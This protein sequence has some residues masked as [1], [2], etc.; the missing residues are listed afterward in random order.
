MIYR[1]QSNDFMINANNPCRI[2]SGLSWYICI[3]IHPSI[4]WWRTLWKS[5]LVKVRV[6]LVFIIQTMLINNQR[7]SVYSVHSTR[8]VAFT[9]NFLRAQFFRGNKN[10][11]LPFMSLLHSDM[12]WVVEILYPIRPGLTYFTWS[13][14]WLLRSWRRKE[15]GHQQPWYWSS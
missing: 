8:H 3:F 11:Y 6:H 12:P 2:I 10:T 9:I 4:L 1:I 7:H 13:I 15:P 5:F 14:S